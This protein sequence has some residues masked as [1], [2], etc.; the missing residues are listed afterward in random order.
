MVARLSYSILSTKSLVS[1]IVGAISDAA[2]LSLFVL[3]AG[4]FSGSHV[5]PAIGFATF[6][7]CLSTFPQTVLYVVFSQWVLM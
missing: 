1:S 3:T 5:N 7:M 6:L 4:P 2:V